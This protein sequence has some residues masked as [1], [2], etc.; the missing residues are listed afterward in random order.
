[1]AIGTGGADRADNAG[2]AGNSNRLVLA[3]DA[4]AE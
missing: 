4:N 1:M 2:L 3:A